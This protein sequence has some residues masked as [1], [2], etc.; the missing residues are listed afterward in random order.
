MPN[1]QHEAICPRCGGVDGSQTDLHPDAVVARAIATKRTLRTL[2][3]GTPNRFVMLLL[4][5]V[6]A[7]RSHFASLEPRQPTGE[8][9]RVSR[10]RLPQK[11]SRAGGD[12][13]RVR[14]N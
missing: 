10:S 5:A 14:E 2:V 3:G 7:S 11:R 8:G 12:S 1:L 4:E 6:G 13:G 9:Q